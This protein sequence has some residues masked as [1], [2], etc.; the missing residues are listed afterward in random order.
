MG[1]TSLQ[2]TIL[3]SDPSLWHGSSS[4]CSGPRAQQSWQ[5][6]IAAM[7]DLLNQLPAQTP[8]T[9]GGSDVLC[10]PGLV[11]SGPTPLLTPAATLTQFQAC[12]WMP[13]FWRFPRT[14]LLPGTTADAWA[15]DCL[16]ISPALPPLIPLPAQDPLTHEQFCLVLTPTF[17]WG[18]ILSPGRRA[19]GLAEEP[20]GS[21]FCQTFNPLHLQPLLSALVARVEDYRPAFR[22]QFGAWL[23]QLP[24]QS[25]DYTIPAQ[26]SE[27]LL[28]RATESPE[29][30]VVV[31]LNGNGSKHS[32][33]RPQPI[34][35]LAAVSHA[36]AVEAT[37]PR[38]AAKPKMAEFVTPT[39]G[40][41]TSSNFDAELLKAI[42]HEVRTPLTTIQTLT[43]L[44]LKRLD[45][46]TDA[47][48][49]LEAIQRECNDQIDRFG[50]FFRAMELTSTP[51]ASLDTSLTTLS[52]R[53]VFQE[54]TPRW[55]Q[56]AQRRQL[57][58]EIDLPA[59]LPAIAIR[60]PQML[61]QVLT[62]LIER[63]SHSLGA[64]STMRLVV[65][66]AGN[67]LKLQLRSSPPAATD[68]TTRNQRDTPML[69]AVGQFLTLQPETGGLSLSL[70]ATKHLFRI[71]GGKL[72]VRQTNPQGEVLTM[73]LPLDTVPS[74]GKERL[75]H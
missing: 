53:Q 24:I 12:V 22:R 54:N 46:P 25:P 39:V 66:L 64:G 50:L 2:D 68:P 75:S 4:L 27:L 55:Q 30:A 63:V 3:T 17:S 14:H 7:V 5:L 37:A 51:A 57:T 31:K 36:T 8:A 60:D 61:D 62:G 26:F 28:T 34:N 58:F 47:L 71:L 67:Q 32:G 33:R 73:F 18:A 13:D 48:K 56:L 41:R 19:E 21:F 42:A 59:D 70:A 72:T 35:T 10:L 38:Q 20:T 16:E 65:A 74:E 11:L 45:L 43:R 15:Q 69:Q 6:A 52:L 44:L 23:A 29:P 1:F 40:E 9:H 49:R